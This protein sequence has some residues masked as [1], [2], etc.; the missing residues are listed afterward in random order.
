MKHLKKF[1]S[2]EEKLAW[3]GGND[4]VMPNVIL[5]DGAV[6]YNAM[7]EPLYVEANEDLTVSFS[8]NAIEYSLDGTAWNS[9]P[10]NTATPTINKGEKV[11]FRATG[12]TP[13]T[14]NGI[15]TFAISGACD[16][17]GNVMSMIHGDNCWSNKTLPASYALCALFKNATT[18]QS[19]AQ[20]ELPAESLTAYCY[21]DMFNGCTSLVDTPILPA[22]SLNTACYY[23][24][25][26]SCSAL[27]ET[28]ILPANMLYEN[29][30]GGMFMY[31]TSLTKLPELPAT[32]VMNNAKNAYQYMFYG[33][34]GLTEITGFKARLSAGY[35][36]TYMFGKCTSL[37]S[38]DGDLS[39]SS[40]YLYQYMFYQC[41][42]L[43]NAPALPATTIYAAC[44]YHMFEGCTSLVNPPE[45]PATNIAQRCY[46]GM[47]KDC[48]SLVNAP[49]L[50]ATN[51]VSNDV[52]TSMFEGCTSL[53]NAPAL[54]AT[55]LK[56]SCYKNMFL[57]CTSLVEAPELPAVTLQSQCYHQMFRNCSKLSYI[58]AMFTTV[59]SSSTTS[60]W[61]S[62]VAS[63]GVF[64][65]NAAATWDVVGT[66]GIP[67]N[68]TIETAES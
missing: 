52:Y 61:V 47:F 58:K 63:E 25:F 65:K 36:Y 27:K 60:S 34:T 64:V 20:L 49:A 19:A 23:Q 41:T 17:G 21:R 22:T 14:T 51:L 9:L 33:C 62:G 6:G 43:V 42:S 5:L 1:N 37:T 53:V 31:C 67:G 39:L 44:Y 13:A 32:V 55:S 45:L 40:N 29:A 8:L 11:Y 35:S 3:L 18:I 16:I 12:L 28:P 26:R 68:W 56:Q 4:H 30:Y 50:P 54:P 59:P 46:E 2:T 7:L 38:F 24:M 57:G 15:G 48:T 66:S 10:A